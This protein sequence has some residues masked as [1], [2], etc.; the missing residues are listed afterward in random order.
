MVRAFLDEAQ[1]FAPFSD[2]AK[3]IAHSWLDKIERVLCSIVLLR[4]V[5]LLRPAPAPR[6]SPRRR[7]VRQVWR[8]VMGSALRK[9]LRSRDLHRRIAALSQDIGALV[10]RLLKRLPR[11][12]TRRRPFLARREGR[13]VSAPTLV[14]S[15]VAAADT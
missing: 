4:A 11:G 2:Q 15:V 8:A 5:R 1:G 13:T 3:A 7:K 12:L 14:V 10:A 6:H 9:A